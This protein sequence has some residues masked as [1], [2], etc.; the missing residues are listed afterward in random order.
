MDKPTYFVGIDI[1]SGTFTSAVGKMGKKWEIAVRSAEFLNNNDGFP[2]YLKWLQA[3][4][5]KPTNSILCMEATGVYNEKLAYFLAAH[6][7][8]FAIEPPLKVKRSFP[9]AGHKSDP[10][11][12]CQISEYAYRFFDELTLWSPPEEIIEKIKILLAIREHCVGVKVGY[13]NGLHAL[14]RKAV[15]VS[16]AMR[17]YEKLILETESEINEIEGEIKQLIALDASFQET[18]NL[19]DSVPGVGMLLA[20]HVLVVLESAPTASTAKSLA[21]YIGICPY[22][23]TSGSSHR[24]SSTSRHYGP[25]GLRR[26]LNTASTCVRTHNPQFREYFERKRAEGKKEKVIFN[27]ISNKLIKIMMGVLRTRTEY[28]PEYKSVRPFHQQTLAESS[29]LIAA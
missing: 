4:G 23:N 24:R 6:Q 26:I 5:I 12:S 21:A 1:A 9:T 3:H 18:V 10:V 25:P 7:Y 13:K 28:V 11:D 20:T 17:K 29:S 2:Q 16:L 22:E 15:Q 14:K 27:N 8:R 19:L